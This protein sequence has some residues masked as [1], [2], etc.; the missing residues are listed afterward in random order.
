M[1]LSDILRFIHFSFYK[2]F[3]PEITIG[4]AKISDWKTLR[5][6][7]DPQS[8]QDENALTAPNCT[9]LVARHGKKIVGFVQLLRL[10]NKNTDELWLNSL[11]VGRS[12]R[13]LGIGTLLSNAVIG[14]T[15]QEGQNILRLRVRESNK[16][17]VQLY[18]KLGFGTEKSE[19]FKQ[20]EK[21]VKWL[22]MKKVCS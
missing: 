17:A 3:K 6:W 12:Y 2:L 15:V 7:L 1:I 18:I 10:K 21:N 4:E 9:N 11:L 5:P 20:N 22:I 8:Q 19:Y 14:L 13:R 16:P